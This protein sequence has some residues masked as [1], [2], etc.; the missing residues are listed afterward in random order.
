MP[1]THWAKDGFQYYKVQS[2]EIVVLDA[3]DTNKKTVWL[4][5]EQLNP[6]RTRRLLPFVIFIWQMT[7]KRFC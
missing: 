2:G 3:R 6:A 4:S 5:K 7:G 1:S